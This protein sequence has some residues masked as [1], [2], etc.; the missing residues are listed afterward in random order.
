MNNNYIENKYSKYMRVLLEESNKTIRKLK[1]VIHILL[2]NLFILLCLTI[3]F[4]IS[5]IGQH[6]E[7][8]ELR[9]EI[10]Q[11]EQSKSDNLKEDIREL[12]LSMNKSQIDSYTNET[13]VI[14]QCIYE[15]PK[16]AENANQSLITASYEVTD[17]YNF[18]SYMDY[19]CITD[20]KS[21]QWQIVSQAESD[22]NGLMKIDNKY[23][24]IALGSA[25]GNVGDKMLIKLSNGKEF[26]AIKADA[27]ADKHTTIEKGKISADGSIAE[28][29]IDKNNL[30]KSIRKM[31]SVSVLDDFSGSIE[32]IS[33]LSDL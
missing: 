13:P 27:K 9:Q 14:E 21:K 22:E 3:F 24:C 25:F 33:I 19:R 15:P 32:S 6:N 23:Y 12:V 10:E 28:F 29:I 5:T 4:C 18:K 31:G 11:L 2:F 20:K 30:N 7:N 1:N 17:K 26:Y 8:I 16:D